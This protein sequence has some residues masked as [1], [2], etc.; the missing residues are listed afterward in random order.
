MFKFLDP[1]WECVSCKFSKLQYTCLAF[2]AGLNRATD[3]GSPEIVQY[4]SYFLPLNVFTAS[5]G[6]NHFILF[7]GTFVYFETSCKMSDLS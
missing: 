3:E 5:I 2:V 4:S 7:S 6:S 1:F